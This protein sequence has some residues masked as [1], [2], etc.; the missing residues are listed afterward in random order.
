LPKSG[1]SESSRLER[2]S[3]DRIGELGCQLRTSHAIVR[4]NLSNIIVTVIARVTQS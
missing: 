3:A 4:R 1:S 2:A